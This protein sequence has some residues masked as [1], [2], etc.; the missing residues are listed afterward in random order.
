MRF[1]KPSMHGSTVLPCTFRDSL[2][3]MLKCRNF[4]RAITQEKK[5]DFFQKPIR[6]STHHPLS[7]YQVSR[8]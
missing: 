5:S 6:S 1:Q 3:T 8:Q 2:L 4:Q 7:A